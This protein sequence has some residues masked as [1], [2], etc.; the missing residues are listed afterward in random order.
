MS[1]KSIFDLDPEGDLS[2]ALKGEGEKSK[3]QARDVANVL[4]IVKFREA[5]RESI[6]VMAEETVDELNSAIDPNYD[7][8]AYRGL[9]EKRQRLYNYKDGKPLQPAAAKPAGPV[10]PMLDATKQPRAV[11]PAPAPGPSPRALGRSR[12]QIADYSERT[13]QAEEEA[14]RLAGEKSELEQ[15]LAVAKAQL[16][17]AVESTQTLR[18]NVTRLSRE[19]SQLNSQL[20]EAEDQVKKIAAAHEQYKDLTGRML[21]A[22]GG[23][24][25]DAF[26][27]VADEIAGLPQPGAPGFVVEA[28]RTATSLKDTVKDLVAKSTELDIAEE[29][30]KK[31]RESREKAVKARDKKLNSYEQAIEAL[32]SVSN[33]VRDNEPE[34]AGLLL[35]NLENAA[36]L[37]SEIGGTD[38]GRLCNA[39]SQLVDLSASA[40]K[41]SGYFTQVQEHTANTL[42]YLNQEDI[43]EARKQ[44]QAILHLGS[45][46]IAV[47]NTFNEL[48]GLLH[49]FRVIHEKLK[50][51][52]GYQAAADDRMYRTADAYSKWKE[53]R[54]EL[55]EKD[56]ELA[57]A[58][59][60]LALLRGEEP[61]PEIVREG[62]WARAWDYLGYI[63]ERIGLAWYSATRR[64]P[65]VLQLKASELDYERKERIATAQL[66]FNHSL[67][68]QDVGDAS[69]SDVKAA[70]VHLSEERRSANRAYIRDLRVLYQM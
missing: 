2:D 18:D 66:L 37:R 51:H 1:K 12:E 7:P 11:A 65:A 53:A 42:R 21:T 28:A 68:D 9:A 34:Q 70:E 58:Q 57:K 44:V 6:E 13:R 4:D 47:E 20:T 67:D 50:G 10:I 30:I 52:E 59:R 8:N 63:G 14:Q 40:E 54:R 48:T 5:P 64:L 46:P 29:D 62:L 39:G 61:E 69:P 15:T 19:R 16:G 26:Y 33:A 3:Q 31:E 55:R 45:M 35:K 24:D 25:Y 17:E 60:E 43:A 23:R 27:S 32:V 56:K 36:D 49:T 22:L 38:L 41:R